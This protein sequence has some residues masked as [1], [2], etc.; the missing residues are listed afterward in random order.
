MLKHEAIYLWS[1][2]LKAISIVFLFPNQI[3]YV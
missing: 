2:T 1:S 3:Q